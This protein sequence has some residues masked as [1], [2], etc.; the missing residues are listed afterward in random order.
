VSATHR[1]DPVL[2]EPV[3]A[4]LAPA[5]GEILVD[6]TFGGGGYSEALLAA[7][8]TRLIGL[9]RDPAAVAR[10][11]ALAVREPRF[12]IV[13]GRFGDLPAHLDALGIARVDGIVLDLGVSSF[14]LDEPGRGFSF[15]DDGPLDMRMD[16]GAGPAAAELIDTSDERTLAGVLFR[17]GEERQARRIA[18]AIVAR[19]SE[20]PLTRTREL[21]ELVAGVTGPGDRRIHPA[22]RTFQALRIWVND[23][24]GELERVLEASEARL[25]PG[26]RLVVVAFHSLEDRIV[27]RFLQQRAAP[28]GPSR[29]RPAAAPRAPTFRLLT[30]QPV[31]PD[32]TETSANPRARSARLRAAERTPA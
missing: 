26:G 16:P 8:A 2:L 27:K 13:H 20:R 25:A 10:G 11:A 4:L 5:P 3:V 31:R 21:A 32:A 6:L 23:E 28:P 17:F 22:T 24:L 19:R 7:G 1:H 9:D 18:R 15:R 29:H 12:Q 14:Q 30:R